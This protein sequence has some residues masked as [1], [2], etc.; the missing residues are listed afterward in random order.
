MARGMKLWAGGVALVCLIAALVYLPPKGAPKWLSGRPY[1]LP[2]EAQQ[3]LRARQLAFEWQ[4]VNG[5]LLGV[6]YR[7]RFGPLLAER[8]GRNQAGPALVIEADSATRNFG[9]PQVRAAID[10]AWARLGIGLS[11]ISVGILL[12]PASPPGKVRHPFAELSGLGAI[13]L[14]PDSVDRATC[15][16]VSGL[17]RFVTDRTFRPSG[18][19]ADWA[20]Q[21]LG[22]CAFYARFGVP[23]PRVEQ[24]LAARS[25]DV[26]ISPSWDRPMQHSYQLILWMFRNPAQQDWWWNGVYSYPASTLACFAGRPE[27]CRLGLARFDHGGQG[28]RPKVVVPPDAWQSSRVNLIGAHSYLASIVGTVGVDRF[29]E[30][31]TTSLPVDSALTLAVQKPV[32]EY[33]VSW[34]RGFS[35]PPRFGAATRWLDA[36]LGL[37]FAVVIMAL[38]ILGQTRRQ[39]R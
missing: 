19:L 17:P 36:L 25:F 26:A 24:W 28:R 10:S 7:D 15:L 12:R 38:A 27:D 13:Y 4:E 3:R 35:Y 34:L 14:L 37:G 5:K 18:D 39:V 30:F 33:T 1:S 23:G 22:P 8:Q 9:E 16:V 20:I 6:S 21:L 2:A 31:W 29:Q 11:K 32:G